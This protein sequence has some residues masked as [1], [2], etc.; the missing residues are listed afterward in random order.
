MKILLESGESIITLPRPILESGQLHWLGL[1]NTSYV[2]KMVIYM[3]FLCCWTLNPTSEPLTPKP[4]THQPLLTKWPSWWHFTFQYPK[5]YFLN[6]WPINAL[7]S[8][9]GVESTPN[10]AKVQGSPLRPVELTPLSPEQLTHF[11]PI[12][13]APTNTASQGQ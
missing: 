12:H 13:Q 1:W 11:Q 3:D 6:F 8:Q 5:P 10:H 9:F 4:Y 2:Y 7:S